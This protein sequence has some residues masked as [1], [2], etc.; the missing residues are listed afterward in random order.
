MSFKITI[1][2]NGKYIIGKLYDPLNRETAK[3]LTKE[4]FKIINST[5]INRILNDV[6][7]VTDV[8]GVFNGYEFAYNDTKS[9]NLPNNI[10][11]AIVT[12]PGD[13]THNFQETVAINAGYS[14]KIFHEIAPAVSWLLQDFH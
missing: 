13:D 12:D 10:R 3:Q 11:A 14:V 9:L 8:M 2:E 4:Y 1:S 6:R 7:S 5:N